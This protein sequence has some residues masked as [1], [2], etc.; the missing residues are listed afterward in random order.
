VIEIMPAVDA[1]LREQP[2]RAKRGKTQ[3]ADA[4][5]TGEGEDRDV[6]VVPGL[7]VCMICVICTPTYVRSQQLGRVHCMGDRERAVDVVPL[8]GTCRVS[9]AHTCAH[10]CVRACVCAR[11][12]VC[13]HQ[14]PRRF[15]VNSRVLDTTGLMQL[16]RLHPPRGKVRVLMCVVRDHVC[17]QTRLHMYEMSMPAP[18]FECN[19]RSLIN[20]FTS[21][22]IDGTRMVSCG[23]M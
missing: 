9:C 4:E 13:V 10:A 16:T 23:V 2:L 21:D 12:C 19:Q 5:P 8:V 11:V 20:F 14:V 7:Q 3:A 18:D 17:A 1:I 22:N 15:F 6:R